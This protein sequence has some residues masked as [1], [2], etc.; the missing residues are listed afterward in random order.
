MRSRSQPSSEPSSKTPAP[1][2]TRQCHGTP[3]KALYLPTS[4][5]PPE[6][7]RRAENRRQQPSEPA[8]R[9]SPARG[10]RLKVPRGTCAWHL[11]PQ[12][13]VA[14]KNVPAPSVN[15]LESRA[16]LP[17]SRGEQREVV[18]LGRS[19]CSASAKVG[20]ASPNCQSQVIG[21][22]APSPRGPQIPT[23]IRSGSHMVLRSPLLKAV[24]DVISEVELFLSSRPTSRMLNVCRWSSRQALHPGQELAA[25]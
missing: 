22:D 23:G 25:V 8:V 6:S 1:A 15:C 9:G 5:T 11:Q 13:V 21:L 3:R 4:D 2:V 7:Y 18:A 17:P 16:V 19:P 24:R 14:P 12:R 10:A 20:T